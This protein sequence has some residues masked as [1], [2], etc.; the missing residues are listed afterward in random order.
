M[1]DDA[2]AA[3]SID[4]ARRWLAKAED[5]LTVA[6][7]VIANETTVNWAACFH[8]QQPAE[9]ALKAVLVASGIDFP[10]SHSL[11]HLL[12]LMP[13]SAASRFDEDDLVE[14]SP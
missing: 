7:V 4:E 3:A 12:A 14:L 5:D 1:R 6:A 8:A 13:A 9:K 11:E 10:R 2:P